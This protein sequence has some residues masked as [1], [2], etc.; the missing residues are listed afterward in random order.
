MLEKR[1]YKYRLLINEKI[2]GAIIGLILILEVCCSKALVI[3]IPILIVR[4]LNVI[5]SLNGRFAINISTLWLFLIFI[6]TSINGIRLPNNK[7]QFSFL[8]NMTTFACIILIQMILLQYEGQFLAVL[9]TIVIV[10][11][12]GI[13]SYILVMESGMLVYRWNDFLMGTSGYRL[14]ISSNINPNT[15]TW[16]FGV[17]ALL[18]IVFALTEH[19]ILFFLLY[20]FELSII[21]FTGSKN[22]LL[23]AFI[24]IMVYGIKAFKQFNI[25]AVIIVLVYIIV[26]WIVIHKFPILYTLI[27]KRIDSMLYTIGLTNST[28]AVSAGI[29]IWSTE[30]RI[31]MIEVAVKMFLE[32][33][34]LGWGIGAFAQYSGFGYYCHN[35]YMEIL[36]SGGI[37]LFIIYYIYINICFLK[38]LYIKKSREKDIAIMLLLSLVLLDFSTVNFY[39]NIIFHVR[40]ILMLEIA[41]W[42]GSIERTNEYIYAKS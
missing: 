7:L 22:G 14:G 20:I 25:K 41:T 10:S 23:L 5:K 34:I 15:I 18:T 12:L 36:V 26:F 37:L 19:K 31:K 2:D 11:T 1:K 13:G 28:K 29:D 3:M 40:T 9:K 30:K 24:P 38:I 27:G 33:P 17:L 16:T 32:K 8:Y 35:N 42:H 4:Y 39:S 6:F 21:F